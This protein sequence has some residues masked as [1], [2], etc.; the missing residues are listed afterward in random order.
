V[1]VDEAGNVY[2][3]DL[4]NNRVQRFAANAANGADAEASY[5]GLNQPHD[6]AIDPNGNVY[7]A[8]TLNSQIL[9]YAGGPD[10]DLD[11]DHTFPGRNFP[12]GMAFS[13]GGDFLVADCG[14]PLPNTG[15][16][17]CLEGARGIYFYAAP[18]PAQ[19]QPPTAVDDSFSTPVNTATTGNVL[20]NDDDPQDSAL[21]VTA[22]TQPANGTV[23]VEPDGDFA[24]TPPADFTGP[25]TFNYTVSNAFDLTDV[26]TVTI[27]VT[28]AGT[29]QP[30]NAVNDSA[31][32]LVNNAVDGNLLSNDSDPQD[33][34]L[35]V[36]AFTQPANGTVA[37][38]PDGDF[39]YTPPTDFVGQTSF[40]YTIEN[41]ADL[42][43]TAT[44]TINVTEEVAEVEIFMP[45]LAR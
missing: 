28:E 22:F 3:A 4:G 15:Y 26:A 44:V 13:S 2:V 10:G 40:T 5:T 36:T 37:V 39:T 25:A 14:S 34:P 33:S 42:T 19:N 17:P 24:Y 27:N 32:T 8:D 23:T 9:V 20:T 43:D 6:V 16:P 29:P 21:T 11:S 31:T 38:K 45:A 35:T 30:P 41:N 7:V 18:E 1:A 12:M